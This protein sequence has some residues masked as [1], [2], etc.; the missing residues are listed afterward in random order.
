MTLPETEAHGTEGKR[1]CCVIDPGWGRRRSA[2]LAAS[3]G[4]TAGQQQP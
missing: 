1:N 4:K 3:E 2:P